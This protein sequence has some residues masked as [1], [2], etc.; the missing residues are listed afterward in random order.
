MSNKQPQP[1]PITDLPVSRLQQVL[2]QVEEVSLLRGGR[3]QGT[4]VSKTDA[5]ARSQRCNNWADSAAQLNGALQRYEE[6]YESLNH[7][8]PRSEGKELLVPLSESLYAVGA[9]EDSDSVLSK[10]S[11]SIRRFAERLVWRG[12]WFCCPSLLCGCGV[13]SKLLWRARGSKLTV[14][15]PPVEIGTGYFVNKTIVEAQAFL[16]RKMDYLKKNIAE[17]SK[18]LDEDVRN[19]EQVSLVIRQKGG[20]I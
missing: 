1:V 4:R 13:H 16:Q 20:Q 3:R 7:L 6:T 12:L 9:L 17:I 2:A 8:G 19:L 10:R 15:S 14:A 5:P 18:K 11:L